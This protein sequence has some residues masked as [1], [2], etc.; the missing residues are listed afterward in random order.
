M[1]GR[2]RPGSGMRA[3]RWQGRKRKFL[4]LVVAGLHID[5]LFVPYHGYRVVRWRE[6]PTLKR[7]NTE[8]HVCQRETR[9]KKPC[10]KSAGK[11]G[12][13]SASATSKVWQRFP[14]LLSHL[15]TTTYDDGEQRRPG[16]VSLRTQGTSFYVAI[17]E[18]DQGVMLT[19][20]AETLDDAFLL[21]EQ[22][23]GAEDAPWEIDPYGKPKK[24]SKR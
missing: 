12:V 14:S 6:A 22:L 1:I 15:T 2:T 19:A 18:P 24:R 9:V 5:L 4:L 3:R 20:V 16:S 17:R 8:W 21:A 13:R 23:L 11:S 10:A 7:P